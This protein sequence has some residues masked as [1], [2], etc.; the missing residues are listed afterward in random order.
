MIG[1]AAIAVIIGITAVLIMLS[2]I[3]S[4]MAGAPGRTE[5]FLFEC[6][7]R[8]SGGIE[9]YAW[10]E[11]IDLSGGAAAISAMLGSVYKNL[12]IGTD[13]IRTR[14]GYGTPQLLGIMGCDESG[15][16]AGGYLSISG[17]ARNIYFGKLSNV[18]AGEYWLIYLLENPVALPAGNTISC[19][20]N[21][22]GAAAE[23][24]PAS[25]IGLLLQI[26][27]QN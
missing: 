9:T 4:L 21:A 23:Q 10:N 3:A 15:A 2:I 8:Y 11:D 5:D 16:G 6:F 19:V 24:H 12:Y 14:R 26:V 20:G 1:S 13:G 27:L 25:G 22:S 17:R 18:A 7:R